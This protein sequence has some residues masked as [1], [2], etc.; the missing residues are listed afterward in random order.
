MA[1]VSAA[2]DAFQSALLLSEDEPLAVA[3]LGMIEFYENRLDTSVSL[4]RR[5]VA[6]D[7][8]QIKETAE[9]PSEDVLRNQLLLRNL[10]RIKLAIMWQ[11]KTFGIAMNERVR[12]GWRRSLGVHADAPRLVRAL[13]DVVP[14]GLVRRHAPRRGVRMLE[15]A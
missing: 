6:L 10:E 7:G 8:E 5:A 12:D 9:A 4:L 1:K 14:V 11:Q 15:Q 13:L 2:N 3:G